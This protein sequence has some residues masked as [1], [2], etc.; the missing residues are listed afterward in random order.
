MLGRIKPATFLASND[1]QLTN[2][3]GKMSHIKSFVLAILCLFPLNADGFQSGSRGAT[4][5][6]TYYRP[7]NTGIQGDYCEGLIIGSDGRPL[8]G[9]YDPS[10]EEG[11]FSRFDHSTGR[12]TNFSNVDYPIIGHPDLTGISRVSDMDSDSYGNI[13]MA[14]GR[15]GLFFSPSLGAGSLLR[16]GDDNSPI[17]GGWNRGVEV[18]PDG[19]I[20]FASY[21]TTWGSGGIAQFNPAGN[22]WEIYDN[23]GDSTLAIQPVG[24]MDYL[25]WSN[26]GFQALRFDTRSGE[27]DILPVELDQP[28]MIV[29][30]NATDSAGNTWMFRWSNP[31][32]YEIQFDC[33]R[34]DGTWL[35]IPEPPF[36]TSV[37]DVRAKSPQLVLVA[38]GSG[39]AWR[40]NGI[41]WSY[42]GQWEATPYTY[43]IDEDASGNVWV[44]GVGGAARR[45]ATSG[46]WQRYRI[47]NTSQFDFF[48]RDLTISRSGEVF[49]TGNAGPGVGGLTKFDGTR[50]I[51]F[52]QLHYGLGEGWPFNGDNSDHVYVR[53]TSNQ[54]LVN[55][56]YEGLFRKD[57]TNWTD[58][59]IGTDTVGD[60]IDD[61]RGRLWVTYPGKLLVREGNLWRE[62]LN[63]GGRKLRST[64]R[65]PGKIWMMG[66]TVVVESDGNTNRIWRIEDFPELDPQSDQFKGLVI[67]SNGMVW[68]GANTV[69]LPQ[70][71]AVIK[72]DPVRNRYTI[73]RYAAA[74]SFPGQYVMPIAAT[75]DGRVWF[76][77]DSDYGIDEQGIFCLNGNQVLR[78]PAPF[79]GRPQ[80]GG[81]PH[82]AVTDAEYKINADGY[83]L[84]LSCA[85]RGIAVL[86]VKTARR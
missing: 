75:P 7:S 46:T 37:N 14:T 22:S 59:L 11:G 54:L 25:V 13:W 2:G 3:V 69:N 39:G 30:K 78:F 23:Q 51:G 40:Y 52:N 71:S 47:T 83:E 68:I 70:N 35:R 76:Q 65:A 48:N 32:S 73:Y 72:L 16:F 18:A 53:P 43:G 81:L 79:E 45:S 38:D 29:G 27:W 82:A 85:S 57:T 24:G 6:W 9:G 63:E 61:S 36:G 34:P 74:W 77:Y 19:T 86:R 44:C 10:F 64:L 28:A 20:W 26:V 56:T 12:W 49:A 55:P 58:L 50:W 15:G 66:E 80:W 8:I 41:D 17:P 62:V 31:E 67:A 60:M 5:S 1:K 33:L 4:F 21:A 84:W 42:L